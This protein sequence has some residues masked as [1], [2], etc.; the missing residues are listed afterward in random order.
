VQKNKEWGEDEVKMAIENGYINGKTNSRKLTVET[1]D[2][3]Y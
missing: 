3:M 1:I 2:L